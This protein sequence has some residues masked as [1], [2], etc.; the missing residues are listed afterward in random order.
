MPRIQQTTEPVEEQTVE[1]KPRVRAELKAAFLAYQSTQQ[2]IKL[3]EGKLADIKASIGE[4]REES[5]AV[6]LELDGFKVQ[7]IAGTRKQLNHK[8][9]IALGCAKA[10]IDEATEEVPTKPYEKVSLPGAKAR[11]T[12]EE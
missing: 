6:A 12:E 5:G 7:L 9:L 3:L 8:R 11:S 10:W 2:Q 4:I 1:L